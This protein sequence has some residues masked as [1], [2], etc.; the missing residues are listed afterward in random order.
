MKQN[1]TKYCELIMVE[2]CC[3]SCRQ[4]PGRN[5]NV[6][7]FNR[8]LYTRPNGA[9]I[10]RGITRSIGFTCC[11]VLRGSDFFTCND[12]ETVPRLH[13]AS[14]YEVYCARAP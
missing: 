1:L 7:L 2:R 10:G 12:P 5:K 9:S 14:S 13:N 8:Y 6:S 4:S 11:S 3:F